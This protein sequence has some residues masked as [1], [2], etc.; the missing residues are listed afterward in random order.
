M[1]YCKGTGKLIYFVLAG[2]L[3][4]N[5]MLSGQECVVSGTYDE[6]VFAAKDSYLLELSLEAYDLLFLEP[7]RKKKEDLTKWV[8]SLPGIAQYS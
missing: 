2:Q 7:E 3:S 5:K 8:L 1:V 4:N 6:T